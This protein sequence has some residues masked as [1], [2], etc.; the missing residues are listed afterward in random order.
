MAARPNY[1]P[2]VWNTLIMSGELHK[3]FA[4]KKI[5][6][7]LAVMSAAT[8]ISGCNSSSVRDDSSWE[9]TAKGLVN[10]HYTGSSHAMIHLSGY[11]SGGSYQ[12]T[13]NEQKTV[14]SGTTKDGTPFTCKK[15][16]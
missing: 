15:A 2:G 8:L 11:S 13:L 16:R 5:K 4:M 1:Y 6:L 9:C 7:V 3:G 12:V 10:S 14:A